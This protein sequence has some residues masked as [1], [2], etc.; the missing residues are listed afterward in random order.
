MKKTPLPL[1]EAVGSS[2]KPPGKEV[3]EELLKR[4]FGH[5]HF[6]TRQLEAIQAA[7]SGYF[8]RFFGHRWPCSV[9]LSLISYDETS[10]PLGFHRKG[11][12]LPYADRRRQVDV[13]PD[14]SAGKGRHRS[15]HLPL[16]R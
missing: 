10:L 5:S 3:L 11:L 13:L 14:P 1:K 7:F 15:C 12:L 16:N 2:K 4:H 6:R 9:N 8:V